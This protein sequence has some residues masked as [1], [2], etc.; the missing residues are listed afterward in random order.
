[1]NFSKFD[2]IIEPQDVVKYSI[3]NFGASRE[4]YEIGYKEMQD[5]I[6]DV[7]RLVF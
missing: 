6:G 1:V 2:Q 5:K 3:F 4:L 7:L